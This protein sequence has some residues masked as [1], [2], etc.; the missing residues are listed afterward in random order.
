[1]KK[2][3]GFTVSLC[4]LLL[5]TLTSSVK[6]EFLKTIVRLTPEAVVPAPATLQSG[7]GVTALA[8]FDLKR[9]TSGNLIGATVN[10]LIFFTTKEPVVITGIYLRE[11]AVNANGPIHIDLLG[12]GGTFRMSPPPDRSTGIFALTFDITGL[13]RKILANP[14]GFY[15]DLTTTENPKG[16]LRAQLHKLTE[17]LANTVTMSSVNEVPPIIDVAARGTVTVTINPVRGIKREVSEITGGEVT[18]SVLY[19]LPPNSE[20]IGLNIHRAAAGTIGEPVLGGGLSSLNSIITPTGKGSLSLTVRVKSS[21]LET[22][23]QLIND[24]A[25]FYVNLQTNTH[26]SGLIRGQLTSLA[27]PPVMRLVDTPFLL[28]T[29]AGTPAPFDL[30]YSGGGRNGAGVSINDRG[31]GRFSWFWSNFPYGAREIGDIPS[32]LLA[33]GGTL[34]VQVG[35]GSCCPP[36][37]NQST[38]SILV[39]A[40]ESKINSIPVTTVDAAKFGNLAAPE[41]IVAAFGAKL[42]SQSVPAKTLP[43]PTQLDGTTVYINGVAAGLLYVSEGQVNYVIPSNTPLGLAEVVVVAK[44][45]TVSRGVVNVTTTAPAIFT[46]RG[47]GAGAPAGVASKDGQNFDILLTNADGS[48][49]PIDAGNYVALFGTGLR[50]PSTSVKITIGGADLDPLFVGPQGSL[51]GIEQINMQIP[52]SLAGKGDVDLVLTLD[53]K[54][55]NTV[56]LRIR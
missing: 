11:G 34:Y 45:G 20:I 12:V 53:G 3:L 26:A 52:Q 43:L 2:R 39:V 4:A 14:A 16:A 17:S 31:A 7:L 44:D 37:R 8:T 50:F 25:S 29:R 30:V 15:L 35:A 40:P 23:K 18:F 13:I 36:V 5:L 24:P 54:S 32:E 19:D 48:P 42:A 46:G 28:T 9:D 22:L 38:P 41:T 56:K 6:A 51:E 55:S 21:E 1:M 10:F 49:V 27:E 33:N 47:D